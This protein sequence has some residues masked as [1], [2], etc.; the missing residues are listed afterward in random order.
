M[1]QPGYDRTPPKIH[2]HTHG[3][4]DPSSTIYYPDLPDYPRSVSRGLFVQ[5]IY[6]FNTGGT[7]DILSA[8]IVNDPGQGLGVPATGGVVIN[9]GAVDINIQLELLGRGF[10]RPITIPRAEKLEIKS[11]W[12]L[13][14][15]TVRAW[16][17]SSGGQVSF[18]FS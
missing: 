14:V 16:S 11:G 13:L 10:T 15:T 12:G 5:D 1:K 3:P 4:T 17:D 2:T 7:G 6:T 18:L 9:H 8:D